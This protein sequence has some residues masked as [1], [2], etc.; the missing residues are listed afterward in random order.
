MAVA[1][2]FTTGVELTWDAI[3]YTQ[4]DGYYGVWGKVQG[5]PS[6]TLMVTTTNKTI[7][8]AIVSGLQPGTSYAF[9]VRT[10]TP[11]WGQPQYPE[12]QQ[13]DLTSVDSEMVTAVTIPELHTIY[14]PL[15]SNP[16]PFET[17]TMNDA[18]I[19]VRPV[20]T[21]GEVFYTTTIDVQAALP[22]SGKFYLS[23]AANTPTAA[24]VDD[25]VAIILNGVT[26]FAYKYGKPGS[27]V[28]PAL[29]EV[30]RAVMAQIAGKTV[31]IE[32]RDVYGDK[33][34]ATALYLIWA[35]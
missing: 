23:A 31:T 5:S 33:V 20:T 16:V 22:T 28:Q 17:V 14:L 35:P 18:A 2:V 19:P 6:Y 13:N 8:H 7:T 3:V 26:L 25:E 15:I 24:K 11:A 32:F 10:F 9:V 1:D 30:P 29:V 4:D 34:S 12:R 21:I 27:G